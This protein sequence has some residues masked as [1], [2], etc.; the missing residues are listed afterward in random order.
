[1]PVA[2]T[3]IV[4]VVSLLLA[5]A[6]FF[7]G[8]LVMEYRGDTLRTAA[9]EVKSAVV[10][11]GPGQPAPYFGDLQSVAEVN[12]RDAVLDEVYAGL[13]FPWAFE[14][15]SDTQLLI[16]EFAGQFKVLDVTTGAVSEV[17][18]TIPTLASAAGTQQIGLLDVALHPQFSRNGLIYFSHA[19]E[20]PQDSKLRALAVSR[21]R[22]DGASI[23][24]VQQLLVAEPFG[25]SPSNFG[26]ALEFDRQ[27]LL[28]VATGDRSRRD[29]SQNPGALTGKILRLQD[30]G[31]VP[32]D[33][34]FIGV[35]NPYNPKLMIDSRIYAMGV[36]NPQGLHYDAVSSIMYET[37]HGPM[38]GDEVNRIDAGGNYGWPVITYGANY[39][40]ELIGRGSAM[41]GM[42]QPL[43][44]YL[45]SLAISPI[46]VYRGDMFGEWDGD[47]LV[48]AMK[49][50]AVS[51]LDVVEG[52][53]KSERQILQEVRGRVRDI[54]VA[55]DGSIYLL[56]QNGGRVLRLSRDPA[57]LGGKVRD[58]RQIYNIACVT[59][60]QS[61]TTDVPALRDAKAW[62]ARVAKGREALYASALEGIGNMPARGFCE[63]CTDEEIRQ[64]VDYMLD[65]I[66]K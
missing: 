36:R 62:S 42:V 13:A 34:P 3:P 56:V 23:T 1:M 17:A 20:D 54:K 51:K 31:S 6:A 19:V 9:R 28:Y 33:N 21:A 30:D 18:G 10:P 40:T 45:P 49:S 5:A 60:H 7:A 25:K 58:G 43:F 46:A 47:L 63:N 11:R 14:F 37:E 29:Q 61:G 44:Y 55:A 38:G 35:A 2:R 50:S 4:V 52:S 57:L 41:A 22:F 24:E 16:T 12:V 64:A 32:P 39:S 15:V 53:V 66:A 59:C 8:M 27:G 26:G 48:G 65:E